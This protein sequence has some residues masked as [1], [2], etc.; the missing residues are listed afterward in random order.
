MEKLDRIHQGR[1]SPNESFMSDSEL[2]PV[3]IGDFWAWSSSDVISNVTRGVLAEYI[4]GLALDVPEIKNGIREEWAAFDLCDPRGIDI[5]VKSAAYTQSWTQKDYSKITFKYPATQNWDAD[6]NA[7]SNEKSRPAQVYVFALLAHKEQETL[8]PL[9]VSQWEF[10]VVPTVVLDRRKRS[11]SSI[12][13]KSL[14]D[15]HGDPLSFGKLKE[16]VGEAARFH[17]ALLKSE[18]FE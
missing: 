14:R 9:D 7:V 8:N 10:Y 11:Q 6:T 2:L 1:R 17:N 3:T 18:G 15:L 16:A 12:T 5:E 4:V 13:L